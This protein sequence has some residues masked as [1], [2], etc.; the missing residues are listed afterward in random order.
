MNTMT[1]HL[2]YTEI[3]RILGSKEMDNL[4]YHEKQKLIRDVIDKHSQYQYDRGVRNGMFRAVNIL[5]EEAEKTNKD[6]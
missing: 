4:S 6:E 1:K 5:T 2:A 3:D